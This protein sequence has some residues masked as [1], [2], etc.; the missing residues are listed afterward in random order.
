ML[1]SLLHIWGQDC[2]YANILQLKFGPWDV[3]AVYGSIQPNI[4]LESRI[5]YCF[6][7][8][9]CTVW[10]CPTLW[11]LY[12]FLL[13]DTFNFCLMNV[14]S[15]Y[16]S[17]IFWFVRFSLHFV[18]CYFTCSWIP[19]MLMYVVAWHRHT[20]TILWLTFWLWPFWLNVL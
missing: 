18:F 17:M 16:F 8:L 9:T 13:F 7:M 6:V 19:P 3:S 4:R 10:T 11:H 15:F 1:G 5:C 2:T 12:S 20:Q 14:V